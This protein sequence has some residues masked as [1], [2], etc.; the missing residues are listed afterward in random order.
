MTMTCIHTLINSHCTSDWKATVNGK[1]LVSETKIQ[2]NSN[3]RNIQMGLWKRSI[4]DTQ[5]AELT[6]VKAKPQE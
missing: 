6:R 2:T 3:T 4:T 5:K 1:F